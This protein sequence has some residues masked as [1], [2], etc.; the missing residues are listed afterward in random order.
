[1]AGG[2]SV[3]GRGCAVLTGNRHHTTGLAPLG[4]LFY[5]FSAR[6]IAPCQAAGRSRDHLAMPADQHDLARAFDRLDDFLAVQGP[7]PGLDAVLALQQAVGIDARERAVIRERVAALT[8][9]GDAAAAG[10]VLLG[11]LVGL[12]AAGDARS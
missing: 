3:A 12:F 5:W 4:R 11:I 9:G 7:R 1:M 8:G 10:P 6:C 2:E